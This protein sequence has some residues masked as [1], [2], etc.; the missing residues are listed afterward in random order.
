VSQ[1]NPDIIHVHAPNFF[2]SIA[3]IVATI[4][5]IPIIA[6][7]HRAEVG[8]VNRPLFLF[9]KFVLAKYQKIIAVSNYTKSLAED[10]GADPSRISV[11]YNSCDEDLF[12]PREKTMAK[13]RCQMKSKLLCLLET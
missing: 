9:R 7:I 11:I 2:S 6:T 5:K 4:K 8:R 10:A 12:C 1:I 13:K 3:T